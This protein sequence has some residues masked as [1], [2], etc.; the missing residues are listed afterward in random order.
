MQML[1]NLVSIDKHGSCLRV[2][3]LQIELGAKLLA[4]IEASILLPIILKN[5]VT[6][7]IPVQVLYMFL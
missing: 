1:Q 6:Y 2:Y 7:V 3:L 4:L 5:G